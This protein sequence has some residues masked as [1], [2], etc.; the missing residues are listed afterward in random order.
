[1]K[2]YPL[3]LERFFQDSNTLG[4]DKR[5]EAELGRVGVANEVAQMGKQDCTRKEA[6]GRGRYGGSVGSQ[7]YVFCMSCQT[8]DV[9]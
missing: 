6:S 3:Y 2:V 9:I 5:E 4:V 1:M 8:V 7:G